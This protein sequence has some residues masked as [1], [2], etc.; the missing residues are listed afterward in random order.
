MNIAPSRPHALTSRAALL[1]TLLLMTYVSSSAAQSIVGTWFTDDSSSK[2]TIVDDGGTYTGKITWLKNAA[3]V[4]AKNS[5]ASLRTR[6]LMGVDIITGCTGTDTAAKGCRIYAPRRGS[7][8]NGEL[9]LDPDGTLK[10][11]VKA[12][13]AGKTQ[14]WTRAAE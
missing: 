13:V 14:T 1:T 11:K 4:D 8:Y 7:T 9:A 12:G 10:V 3:A 6:P 2:V 5:D